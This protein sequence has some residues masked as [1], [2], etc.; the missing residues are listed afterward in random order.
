VVFVQS[1]TTS[2]S[3]K[4]DNRIVFGTMQALSSPSFVSA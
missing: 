1:D 2:K 4:A 3:H